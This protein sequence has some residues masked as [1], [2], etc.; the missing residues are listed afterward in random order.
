MQTPLL[1]PWQDW[2][3]GIL[4]TK[5]FGAAVMMGPDWFLKTAFDR[6]RYTY[7]NY[8]V[9]DELEQFNDTDL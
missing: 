4:H 9:I 7:S 5:I 1:F 2:A 8:L 3:M 6:V